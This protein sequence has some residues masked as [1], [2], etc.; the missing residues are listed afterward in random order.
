MSRKILIQLSLDNNSLFT[1]IVT[2]TGLIFRYLRLGPFLFLFRF[3]RQIRLFLAAY[4]L[5]H[6]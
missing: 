1:T 4:H 3:S 6:D 5:K 2:P